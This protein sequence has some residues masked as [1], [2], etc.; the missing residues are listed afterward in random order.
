[1]FQLVLLDCTACL[2]FTH[3]ECADSDMA[4]STMALGGSAYLDP[5]YVRNP[6]FETRPETAECPA[7]SQ[8]CRNGVLGV[9]V[10]FQINSQI[11]RLGNEFDISQD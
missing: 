6:A 5:P 3:R 2:L 11:P 10:H 4:D 8:L 1:M 9:A 7:V